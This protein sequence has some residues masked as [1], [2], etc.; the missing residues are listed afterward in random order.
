MVHG[1]IAQGYG[2]LDVNAAFPWTE[3][4]NDGM[5]GDDEVLGIDPTRYTS[6][7]MFKS[8]FHYSV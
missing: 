5:M 7:M 2:H 3:V 1:F 4:R 8:K 6:N